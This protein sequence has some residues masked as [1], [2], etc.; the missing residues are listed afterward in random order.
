MM[1]SKKTRLDSLIVEKGLT[2]SRNRA[3]AL[4]LEGKVY[5]NN[6]KIE[7]AGTR[8]DISSEVS[9]R[10]QKDNWVSRGAYKL[11]HALDVFPVDPSGKICL[12]VGSSTGGFCQV[13]L[14]RGAK[15]IY[16]VDVGYGQLAW[17][18]RNDERVVVMER[19]NARNL[20]PERFSEKIDLVTIDV[21]FIS[22]T[23]IFPA[24]ETLIAPGGRIICLVK[25]QFEA[26]REKVGKNGVVRDLSVHNKVL[27]ELADFIETKSHLDLLD[28][29]FSPIKGPKGNIEFLFYISVETKPD[30]SNITRDMIKRIV[31]E[32]HDNLNNDNN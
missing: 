19:T 4:I 17:Q 21:S 6:E 24:I 25:P 27:T 10:G 18:L 11:L 15:K 16:S 3:L 22:L 31:F 29:A 1:N 23:K 5:V 13:L 32:G 14:S 8:V 2:Q 12:D 30:N 28:I 20:G 9:I 7:K 26:G